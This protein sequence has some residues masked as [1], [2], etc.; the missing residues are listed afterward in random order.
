MARISPIKVVGNLPGTNCGECGEDTCMAF[1][2][3]LIDHQVTMNMCKPLFSEKKYA[4]KLKKLKELATP[5]IK[6]VLIGKG[7]K[8]A[9]VGDEEVM[10]RHEL[11]YYHPSA[12]FISVPDDDLDDLAKRVETIDKYDLYRLGETYRVDGVAIRCRSGKADQFA[13]AVKKSLEVAPNL[14]IALCSIDPKILRAGAEV[15][16]NKN[17]L[18]YAATMENWEEVGK[19]ALEFNLPL[20]VYSQDLT[21]LKTLA[22]TYTDAGI[23]GII[24]DPGC[25]YGTGNINE[26]IGKH[27]MLKR[28]A[29]RDDDK[30]IGYPTLG[31]T[32]SAYIGKEK[33][34]GE[35]ERI[36]LAYEE[37][38]MAT[39]MF[40]NSVNM[41]IMH[42]FDDWFI[43]AM[44]VVRENI[45]SD[46]RINPSV[47]AKLY[48]INDPGPDDPVFLTTNYTMTYYTLQSDLKDMKKPAWLLVADTEGISVESAVA[49]GQFSASKVAEAIKEFGLNDKIK[50]KIIVI[51]G[52]AARISGE[53]EELANWKV[54]VGPRDS[55]GIPG[56]MKKYDKEALMKAWAEM[57]E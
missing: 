36:Q 27:T 53:L 17:P 43:L 57:Q 5:P 48:E 45:Y 6:A 15:A 32:S 54:V 8:Q 1:A 33:D 46:P 9:I 14:P 52:L 25:I 50:H 44:I 31:V 19:I 12:I 20:V 55:S 51:P 16:K 11:T 40:A 29:I 2:V 7:P 18:L 39:L 47:D 56:L 37:G 26:T 49:G 41:L 34:M 28:S 10:Y 13:K 38:K 30:D 4:K 24:L 23:S 22:K 21:E 35:G 3:K 42:N